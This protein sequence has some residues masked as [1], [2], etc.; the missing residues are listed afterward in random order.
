MSIDIKSRDNRLVSFYAYRKM[1]DI[2]EVITKKISCVLNVRTLSIIMGSTATS[3][4]VVLLSN[5]VDLNCQRF[6]YHASRDSDGVG[7]RQ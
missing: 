3:S 2:I 6:V 5:L 1:G 4:M 7:I